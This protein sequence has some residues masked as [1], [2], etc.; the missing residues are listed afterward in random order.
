MVGA[1]LVRAV[2]TNARRATGS[3]RSIGVTILLPVALASLGGWLVVRGLARAWFATSPDADLARQLEQSLEDQREL[4]RLAPATTGVR[5]DRYERAQAALRR[6]RILALNRK[7]MIWSHE[8][9]LVAGVAAVVALAGTLHVVGRA[10]R[11][12]RLA[13]LHAALGALARGQP[14]VR[15]GHTGRDLLG[16]VAHMV[17][18]VSQAHAQDRVR[19]A[20]LGVLQSWQEAARRHAHEM[21]TPLTA[22]QLDVERLD[23]VAESV[24]DAALRQRITDLLAGLTQDLHRLH[25]FAQAYAAFGR[26]P[27]PR[28]EERDLA[29]LAAQFVEHF[30]SAWPELALQLDAPAAPCLARFDH[31]LLRQVLVNLC[32]NSAAALR[33][34][35]RTCGHVCLTLARCGR[36]CAL[37]VSDDG[38]GLSAGA[39]ARLFQPYASFRKGGT[40]LGLAISRKIL[41]DHGGDL[42]LRDA[43][44]GAC[45]R[46]L[47]PAAAS[48]EKTT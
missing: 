32:E 45:F 13:E 44:Q 48:K 26:L 30:G 47:I 42:E 20:S 46:I 6:L 12:R 38:P 18:Q 15:L 1:H 10:Q 22:A 16:R 2:R 27:E 3:A 5:R 37:D 41:L 11:E 19:L 8:L 36:A 4:A 33:D 34:A 29:A 9:L 17:E 28:L 24:R 31:E 25:A 39:R 35:G 40:G 14:D 23:E 43:A 21:R 7:A